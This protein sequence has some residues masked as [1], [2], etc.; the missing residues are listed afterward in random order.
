MNNETYPDF[1]HGV[2]VGIISGFI[3]GV[4]W[5][6]LCCWV[7]SLPAVTDVSLSLAFRPWWSN[8]KSALVVFAV[9]FVL[10]GLIATL[11]PK[12]RH[13]AKRRKKVT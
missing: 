8:W 11:R 7:A 4:L 9:V 12:T 5:F 2:A 1:K 13:P 6:L 10:M 3:A